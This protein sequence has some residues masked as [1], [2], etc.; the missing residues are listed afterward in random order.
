MPLQ[1]VIIP[2]LVYPDL[3]SYRTGGPIT[4][5]SDKL[6]WTTKLLYGFGDVGNAINN[7]AIQF[8]LMI[9]YTD[10]VLVYPAIVA[11]AL[12]IGKFWDA[13]N[14]PLFG[15]VSDRTNSRFGKRRVYMIFG[16]LPL[17]IALILLWNIPKDLA[18]FWTFIWIAWTFILFDTMWTFTNVPYYALTAELTDAYD[19]RSSLTAFR[20]VLGV[21]G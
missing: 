11:N 13:I 16:A 9:F 6:R 14:D 2:S 1:K 19:E 17:A 7:S 12:L 15:W 18:E 3:S 10:A 4:E 5:P 21:P 20:M 8:F